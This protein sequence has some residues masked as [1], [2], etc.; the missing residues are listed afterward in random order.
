MPNTIAIRLNQQQLELV[1][2]TVSRLG[3]ADREQALLEGLRRFVDPESAS[4]P[5]SADRPRHA[6]PPDREVLREVTIEPGTGK[7][8][9]LRRG[10]VLRIAQTVGGQCADF[11]CFNL[12]DYKEFF[13][14]GRTRHMHGLHPSVG[15][16]LWSA[17]P[18]ERPMAAIVEDTAGTNDILY[19][20][21]SGF[22]F[23]YQ[24]GLPVHTNCHDIQ[25]EAQ[26]EYGLTPDDVHDSFNFFMH[27]GVDA[28][29]RPFIAENT[30]TA[31][32]YVELLAL[33]DL[34]A[35]P[36][37]CGA[38]VMATSSFELKPLALTV[39]QG[40]E[41]DW[42]LLEGRRELASFSNQRNP[43]MF[44]NRDIKA[45]RELRSDPT[46][47][48]GFT[49][50]PLALTTIALELPDADA[51]VVDGLVAQGAYGHDA[52]E[53]VR[54]VWHSWWI[55]EYMQGPKHFATGAATS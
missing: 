1:D 42:A 41:A 43:G 34:L 24:Y 8:L 6:A 48:P 32:D 21:C 46:Y 45:D 3:L 15:D 25:A 17:P 7:A 54:F 4:P 51:A 11:N 13:H 47:E 5:A 52:G 22:L 23:E 36:N 33:M 49:N 18:R 44:V 10:Q 27:T 31:G 9:E 35:V 29:G 19:P 50:V 28:A 30:A 26:R 37:V 2:A 16:F 12:V 39:M 38:D 20:R 40:V 14:T 55:R 53:V